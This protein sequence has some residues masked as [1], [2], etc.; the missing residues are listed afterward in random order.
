M[1][2]NVLRHRSRPSPTAGRGPRPEHAIRLP[3]PKPD[4]EVAQQLLLMAQTTRHG[5]LITDEIGFITWCND[6]VTRL[7]GYP[8]DA[9]IG[10]PLCGF[11]QDH[12]GGPGNLVHLRTALEQRLACCTT[13]L[14]RTRDGRERWLNIDLQPVP[15]ADGSVRS[16]V[17]VQT[18]ITEQVRSNQHFKSLIDSTA[19]VSAWLS[20]SIVRS[21][22]GSRKLAGS[23]AMACVTRPSCSRSSAASAWP[24]R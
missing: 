2:T 22:S 20:P 19:A 12:Q 15:D 18:D 3:P 21:T 23:F 17:V 14:D 6:A 24:T 5:L 4:T 7:S 16:F 10:R 1:R 11:L 9:V 8:T 13:L